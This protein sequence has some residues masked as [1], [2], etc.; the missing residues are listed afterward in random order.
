MGFGLTIET[1]DGEDYCEVY[2]D[3]SSDEVVES[4]VDSVCGSG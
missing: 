2:G 3:E 4:A 1:V